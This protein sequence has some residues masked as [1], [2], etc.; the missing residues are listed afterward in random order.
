LKKTVWYP[1]VYYADF[2][3]STKVV[4]GK[5]IQVGNSYVI[6]SPDLSQLVDE[7]LTERSFI[8]SHFSD[9]PEVLMRNFIEDLSTLHKSHIMRMTANARVP[10]LSRKEEE[11]YKE[12]KICE[13]CKLEFG[14][15]TIEGDKVVK[16]RHHD[17]VTNK[18]VGAWCSRCNFKNNFRY[19]KTIVVFH[20]FSGYDGY[21]IIKYA[22]KFMHDEQP[23]SYNTQKIISKSRRSN[24][25][26][27][28]IISSLIV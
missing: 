26:S 28:E 1:F 27:M 3:A 10:K 14:T 2:E 23:Y 7:S 6:F 24:S 13:T 18:F 8:K 5:T 11:K 22:T 9:D 17:H 12:A 20:N 4:D 19:F 16:V 21:F 25:S 15:R